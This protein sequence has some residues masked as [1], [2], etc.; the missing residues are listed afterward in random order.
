MK[1][2]IVMLLMAV[3]FSGNAE[4]QKGMMGVGI[5]GG[6]G[7]DFAGYGVVPGVGVKFQYNITDIIRLEPSFSYYFLNANTPYGGLN[8]AGLVNAHIF[9][10]NPRRLRPYFLAGI[11]YSSVKER[12][13]YYY[14]YL[15]YKYEETRGGFAFDAGL[16][17]DCRLSHRISLQVEA[18]I[19]KQTNYFHTFT[20]WILKPNIGVAFNF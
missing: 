7:F 18:V 12:E 6:I 10:M 14:N 2:I 8:S 3:A 5:N 9:F 15:N 16:G 17:L 11:G 13:N 1:K 19:L 20:G 4:A